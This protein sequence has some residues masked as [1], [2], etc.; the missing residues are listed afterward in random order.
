MPAFI[1]RLALV[2][3]AT[4]VV[5]QTTVTRVDTDL[6]KPIGRLDLRTPLADD[7]G[8]RFVQV[9]RAARVPMGI[10]GRVTDFLDPAR[11]PGLG[12]ASITIDAGD[13][14]A[15]LAQLTSADSGYDVSFSD[16]V[17]N[18]GP[19]GSLDAADDFLNRPIERFQVR[20]A[21]LAMAMQ[22]L[23]HAMNPAYDPRNVAFLGEQLGTY[24]LDSQAGLEDREGAGRQ[25]ADD[26]FHA[27]LEAR[28]TIDL[29]NA[30]PRQILNR[31]V[32]E[33]GALIWRASF[34]GGLSD[35]AHC[36]LSL[37]TFDGPTRAW[38]PHRTGLMR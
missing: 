4:A 11:R 31:F 27:L 5:P 34:E 3:L 33:S 23:R 28:L 26:A 21:S 6:A 38:D 9:A 20:D 12:V 7:G 24:P 18:V 35:D 8:G 29:V 14:R 25:A 17:I 13:V 37:T 32:L 15:A 30:S 16:L 2:A 22:E 36:I 19:V 1:P 10:E